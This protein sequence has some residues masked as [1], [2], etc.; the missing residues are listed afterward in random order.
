MSP[1]P[2]MFPRLVHVPSREGRKPV[3][4]PDITQFPLVTR[5]LFGV[6][7]RVPTEVYASG[8]YNELFLL[9]LEHPDDDAQP[10]LP[11]TVLARVARDLKTRSDISLESEVATM[12]FVRQQCPDIPVPTVYGYVPTRDNAVGLPFSVISYTEGVD[13]HGAPWEALPLETKLIGVRDF[14]RIVAQLAQLHFRAIGSIYFKFSAAATEPDGFVLGPASWGK[15]ESAARA[16]ALPPNRAARDCGPW[17]SAAQWLRASLDDEIHFVEALPALAKATSRRG[18][19]HGHGDGRERERRLQLAQRVL[20]TLRARVPVDP[21]DPCAR[22]P[23]VLG[24]LDLN[25]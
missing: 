18:H 9:E 4:I 17:K 3:C 6:P 21:F 24:H 14:A 5:A 12:V 2:W 19:G 1:D 11:R 15:P 20:P 16:A 23:F 13:M 8:T 7:C 22:G 25:P 10:G